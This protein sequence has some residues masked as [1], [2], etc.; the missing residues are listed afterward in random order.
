MS[1]GQN[2]CIM[3]SE[4][5]QTLGGMH[6]A[7]HGSYSVALTPYADTTGQNG[8]KAPRRRPMH[9]LAFTCAMNCVMPNL[10]SLHLF[11]TLS[12]TDLDWCDLMATLL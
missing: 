5:R 10:G 8:W 7:A 4:I 1:T 11:L 12:A 9:A 2:F 6:D 3:P